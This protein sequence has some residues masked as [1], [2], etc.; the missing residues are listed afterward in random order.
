MTDEG[1][2]SDSV[3]VILSENTDRL[4]AVLEILGTDAD[5]TMPEP[6][7]TDCANFSSDEDDVVILFARNL[8]DKMIHAE[9]EDKFSVEALMAA[10]GFFLEED[11]KAEALRMANL[12]LN[13]PQGNATSEEIEKM[14]E[15]MKQ[16]Q[17]KP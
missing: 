4:R 6:Y 1:H 16:L 9:V 12:G 11:P 13:A 5:S 7:K 10:T 8:R 3:S 14:K 2:I 17:N 15:A